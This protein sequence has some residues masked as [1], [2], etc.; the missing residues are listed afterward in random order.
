MEEDGED[1]DEDEEE[2]SGQ[3]DEEREEEDDIE[4]ASVTTMLKV[5]LLTQL[6]VLFLDVGRQVRF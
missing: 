4:V 6:L 5:M 3:G 1:E 2:E